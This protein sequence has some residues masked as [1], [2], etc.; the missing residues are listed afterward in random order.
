MRVRNIK[1]VISLGL[2]I[3]AIVLLIVATTTRTGFTTHYYQTTSEFLASADEYVGRNVRIN[4]KVVAGSIVRQ[5]VSATNNLP[6][7]DFVIG[8]TLSAHVPVR[9]IGT[10]VPDAFRA[11]ADVVVEG[12]FGEN[13]VLDAKRLLA[14]CPS[15]YEST[16]A[17]DTA[18]QASVENNHW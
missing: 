15:K 18:T 8:D 9:Y 12:R 1:L 13:G 3:A 14:K 2:V 7:I 16:P 5:E 10:T 6:V 17:K 11:E 4:G